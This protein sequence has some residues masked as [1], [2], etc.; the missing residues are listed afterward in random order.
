M[1]F[2]CF[3][4]FN[5]STCQNPWFKY[6]FRIDYRFLRFRQKSNMAANIGSIEVTKTNDLKTRP[7]CGILR[8]IRLPDLLYFF[9]SCEVQSFELEK[10]IIWIHGKSTLRPDFVLL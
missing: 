4:F 1:V 2:F 6:Q 7:R 5:C 10:Y 3:V 9:T 8:Y